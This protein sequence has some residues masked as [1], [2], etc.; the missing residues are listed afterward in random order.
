M[1]SR[2]RHQQVLR[3]PRRRDF[4]RAEVWARSPPGQGSPLCRAPPVV[5]IEGGERGF[6]A[7]VLVSRGSSE[8]ESCACIKS[9]SSLGL[10]CPQARGGGRAAPVPRQGRRARPAVTMAAESTCLRARV[11]G[12]GCTETA[13]LNLSS[14][15]V[16]A[17]R[18]F[19]VDTAVPRAHS[20][21]L[22]GRRA[23]RNAVPCAGEASGFARCGGAWWTSGRSVLTGVQGWGWDVAL[24]GLGHP[25][26]RCTTR[27]FPGLAPG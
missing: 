24:P 17:D 6:H 25:S 8:T 4:S 13:S 9:C 3:G 22:A 14:G 2:L 19:L 12:E 20:A 26:G 23:G 5:L 21:E 15:C 7:W 10:A 1:L 16:T 27:W 18:G 11:R